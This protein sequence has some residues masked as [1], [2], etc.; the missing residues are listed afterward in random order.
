MRKANKKKGLKEARHETDTQSF[1]TLQLLAGERRRKRKKTVKFDL[2]RLLGKNCIYSSTIKD[3]YG[4]SEHY[5]VL[6]V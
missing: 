6:I 2:Y 5:V 1:G 3:A 4:T